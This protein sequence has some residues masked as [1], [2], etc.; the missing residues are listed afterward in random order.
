MQK[1]YTD[2]ALDFQSG[3]SLVAAHVTQGDK[4]GGR[5]LR[6]ALYNGGQRVTLDSESDTV[7]LMASVD[8]MITEAGQS[9]LI[10]DNTVRVDI[11]AGLTYV[12]GI[13]H[14]TVRVESTNGRVHTAL[15]DLIVEE[16]PVSPDMPS[17]VAT[18]DIVDEVNSLA[19]DVA[20]FSTNALSFTKNYLISS[21]ATINPDFTIT[22][23]G[24]TTVYDD[25]GYYCKIPKSSFDPTQNGIMIWAN[26]YLI[27][28]GKYTFDTQSDADYVII[29]FSEDMHT[30]IET[31]SMKV[32]I[33]LYEKPPDSGGETAVIN[34]YL[35]SQRVY[36]TPV[37]F[38]GANLTSYEI[39][40]CFKATV[41]PT[42]SRPN[43]F[44]GSAVN[45]CRAP[46]AEINNNGIWHGFAYSGTSWGYDQLTAWADCPVTLDG[47]M[48]WI[49]VAWDST[50][51]KQV[52]S[53][54]TD[55]VTY[56]E[57]SSFSTPS[58]AFTPSGDGDYI[59]LGGVA[60]NG[61]HSFQTGNDINIFNSYIKM[62]GMLVFGREVTA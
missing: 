23:M 28:D 32:D 38:S 45:F 31:Y 54:S 8:G 39:C 22:S 1:I 46:S 57:I 43:T 52:L 25:D 55:G 7:T 13:E 60:N 48:Q 2:L 36:T 6:L 40:V 16:S 27:L 10:V 51:Q 34:G 50:E 62:N 47:T 41:M 61:S 42:A 30:L 11:L 56:T 17:V 15:F 9:C 37:R 3:K 44:F 29:N 12:S 58:T 18:A 14:C 35:P 49:K 4:S 24:S 20:N 21:W 19:E 59:V 33:L 5:V 26:I 53:H